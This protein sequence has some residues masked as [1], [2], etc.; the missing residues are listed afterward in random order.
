VEG[1]AGIMTRAGQ[2]PV[3]FSRWR[4]YTLVAGH[5]EVR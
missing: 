2:E 1:K 5:D 4:G 3:R